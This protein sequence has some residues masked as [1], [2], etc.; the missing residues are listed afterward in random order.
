M[1]K[2]GDH[3]SAVTTKMILLG[4]SGAGKT[5]ALA[6]LAAAGYNVRVLDIDNGVDVLA[7]LL[8]DPKT[9]YP[10]EALG[11]VDYVTLTD[12]MKATNG[13]L[14]PAKAS[15]WQRAVSLLDNWKTE[16]TDFGPISSWT[17]QDVL[18]IDSLS[19]LSTAAVNFVL[20]M[21]ARLGQK[22]HLSDWGDAQ[23]M[24]EKLMQMLY[25]DGV[26]CNVI[27]NTH[28]VYIGE[29]GSAQRGYPS[30]AGSKLPQ[31]IGRY[32]NTILMIKSQG[33]GAMVKRKI[34]TN[35]TPLVELKNSAP[36]RVKPDYPIESGLADYFRDVQGGGQGQIAATVPANLP[37]G[38]AK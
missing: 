16:D 14:M 19:T 3:P 32:F 35:S 4:D 11:R 27:V 24:I 2:L 1:T 36:M 13:K 17:P 29:E 23:D 25:D 30:C 37:P 12:K 28:V 8:N 26:K 6:S 5:G 34:L 10:K 18:V 20:A 33:S 38:L 31:K 22:P 21:N 7:N 15:V 9:T